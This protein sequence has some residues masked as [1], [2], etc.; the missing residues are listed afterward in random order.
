MLVK[1][2]NIW[3]LLCG[4]YFEFIQMNEGDTPITPNSTAVKNGT[5]LERYQIGDLLGVGNQRSA[6]KAY[7]K[8]SNSYIALSFSIYDESDEWSSVS[9]V[10]ISQILKRNNMPKETFSYII[11]WAIVDAIPDNI[12]NDLPRADEYDEE[13]DSISYFVFTT[14]LYEER[15]N[16]TVEEMNLL[17]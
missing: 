14:N 5:I 2:N 17:Y 9:I 15:P 4:N 16:I 1:H 11:S 10:D 12:F 13:D 3:I 8:I 6:Y 7:D